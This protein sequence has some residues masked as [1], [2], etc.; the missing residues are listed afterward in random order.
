MDSDEQS[1]HLSEWGVGMNPHLTGWGAD[2]YVALA[3]ERLHA[4]QVSGCMQGKGGLCTV[5]LRANTQGG[6]LGQGEA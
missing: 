2:D 1:P 3:D 4:G 5:R 6:R